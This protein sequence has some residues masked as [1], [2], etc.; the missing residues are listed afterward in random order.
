M[1]VILASPGR[2]HLLDLARELHDLGVEVHFYSYVPRKRTKKFGL[3]SRCHV[4]LLP[5][6]FP[7][8]AWE[9]LFPRLF[10][11][12]LERLMCWALDLLTIFRMRPCDVF[13]CMS[14]MYLQAPRFARWRYGARVILHR[15]SRHI[16]SQREIL[17]RLP[18]VQQVT[19]F[20]VR[21]ELQG[22][23]IA[24]KIA[25][26]STH[27]LESFKPWPQHAC[28]LFVTPYGVDLDHF[29][30][31]TQISRSEPT[32][33]FVGNWSYQKG[34]DVLTKAINDLDGVRL[35]HVGALVDAPFPDGSQFVHHDPVPQLNLKSFYE[36]AH[37]FALAS[38]QDG[39]AVVQCQA[40]ASGL[41]LVCTDRAGGADLSELLGLAR[42]IRVVPAG[43]SEALRRALAQALDD[44][45]GNTGIA[46]I[47][48][49]EREALS[50]RAY[51]MRHL[52]VMLEM[53]QP[54]ANDQ[55]RQGTNDLNHS[56][57]GE[58]HEPKTARMKTL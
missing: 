32:V 29:P 55:A 9:R 51:A 27:V 11:G 56:S 39:F 48:S 5:F 40:L 19:P 6:L 50:W 35:I 33:L 49:A 42:L 16:L 8:V 15:G 30:L 37:V 13:V 44:S 28:K 7:L 4:A 46:R 54:Q 3:P 23:T 38:R 34:V 36:A 24:D 26:P 18:G 31:R 17:A 45:T 41:S 2:F 12:T 53:Q 57:L 20:V 47:T 25:V 10:P 1:R 58:A 21:R 43:D 14:G 22:Y 52:E